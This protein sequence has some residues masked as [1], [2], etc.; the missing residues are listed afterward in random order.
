MGCYCSI[1]EQ[2]L[3]HISN[4]RLDVFWI[5]RPGIST[6]NGDRLI[7]AVASLVPGRVL[8][9]S[10]GSGVNLAR[11]RERLPLLEA[12]ASEPGTQQLTQVA[13]NATDKRLVRRFADRIACLRRGHV[14]QTAEIKL[15]GSSL[16]R[17]DCA[18]CRRLGPVHG[19]D[20]RSV[21]SHHASR[22]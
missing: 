17:T 3:N 2:F 5:W 15:A 10:S 13:M 20:H 14:W 7:R 18:R 9:A 11:E 12:L 6:A 22:H 21:R 8:Y 1:R 4:V 19:T 16:L